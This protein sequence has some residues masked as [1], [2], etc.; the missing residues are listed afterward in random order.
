MLKIYTDNKWKQFKYRNEVPVKVLADYFDHLPEEEYGDGFIKYRKTWYHTS[1]FMRN[2][3]ATD[4]T[5]GWDG[6]HSDSYFSG[7]LIKLSDDGE[8]YKIGTY[9]S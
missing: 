6:Y 8:E 1:D 5:K 4:L 2:S 7:V 9:I 3:G